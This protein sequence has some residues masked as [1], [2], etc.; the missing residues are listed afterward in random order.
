MGYIGACM[1]CICS[2]MPSIGIMPGIGI[3]GG[4]GGG[5]PPNG[6]AG[7]CVAILAW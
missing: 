5:P 4:M 6:A 7:N 2:I 1:G 3:I